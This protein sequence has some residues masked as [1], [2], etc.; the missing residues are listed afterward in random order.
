MTSSI[1][2]GLWLKRC[3]VI[4]DRLDDKSVTVEAKV[5]FLGDTYHTRKRIKPSVLASYQDIR[6]IAEYDAKEMILN[7]DK[8]IK[9]AE[10]MN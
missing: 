10:E 2:G 6:E 1:A 3:E 9:A 5:Y 8:M 4:V 7:L